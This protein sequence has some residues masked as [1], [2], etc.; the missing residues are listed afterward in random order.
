MADEVIGDANSKS[1]IVESNR[2]HRI[3]R[4]VA[5]KPRYEES[6]GLH[7]DITAGGNGVSAEG[8]EKTILDSDGT[9]KSVGARQDQSPRIH[10]Q[11]AR[12]GDRPTKANASTR[13]RD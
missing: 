13:V 3:C 5:S 10:S 9:S 8:E 6:A 1:P 4:G 7:I 11:A 12:T 2:S